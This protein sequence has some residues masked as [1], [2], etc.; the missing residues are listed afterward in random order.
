M[1]PSLTL[2]VLLVAPPD[3]AAD[4][5]AETKSAQATAYPLSQLPPS[6]GV[7]VFTGARAI[8]GSKR[9]RFALRTP[10]VEAV[11]PT[12]VTFPRGIPDVRFVAAAA[13]LA[14]HN[15][16]RAEALQRQFRSRTDLPPALQAVEVVGVGLAVTDI[17]ERPAD[18]GGGTI[19][20]VH[21]S[22]YVRAGASAPQ[23]GYAAAAEGERETWLVKDGSLTLLDDDVR[24]KPF[25]FP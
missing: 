21:V 9:Y 24:L 11:A 7:E 18:G 15:P 10:P 22:Y 19:L 25:L 2:A 1:T 3:A 5:S 16:A 6:V 13:V 4:L 12:S 23:M 14:A 8:D 17:V 20:H